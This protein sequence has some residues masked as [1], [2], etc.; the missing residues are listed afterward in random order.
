MGI[1]THYLNIHFASRTELK[2]LQ[3]RIEGL[4]KL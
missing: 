1:R 3:N 2:D 4:T